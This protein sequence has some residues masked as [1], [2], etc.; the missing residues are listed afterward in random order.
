MSDGVRVGV[1]VIVQRTGQV[2]LGLR[3]G[4]HGA[5][6]WALPGGHLEFGETP[7]DCAAREVL[8]ETGLVLQSLHRGPWTSDVFAAEQ[9]HYLT[10]FMLAEAA[11]GEPQ[12][13]E[14]HKCLQWRWFDWVALPQPLFAPLQSLVA[15]GWSPPR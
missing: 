4:A 9:R 3:C 1:G 13:L 8:E 15:S 10:V 6:T 11:S 7:E 12:R 2:L 14:P 5:G